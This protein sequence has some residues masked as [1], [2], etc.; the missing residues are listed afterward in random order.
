ML[1]DLMHSIRA[2]FRRPGFTL[3]ATLTIALGVGV[4][5]AMF[6]IV[7]GVLWKPFPYP[8]SER[9]VRFNENS[10]SGMLNNSAPNSQDWKSRSKVLED[11]SAY[12]LFPS[13]TVHVSD[14]DQ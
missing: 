12:R 9:L 4:N 6:T 14:R 7:N 13:I 5:T 2:L 3:L 11:V 8:A 10:P 1:Q